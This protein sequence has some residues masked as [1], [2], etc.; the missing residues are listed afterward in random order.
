MESSEKRAELISARDL[1]AKVEAAIKAAM[2]RVGG[3]GEP[4]PV[5]VK[6]ELIGR[7][8]NAADGAQRFADEVTK[9]IGKFGIDAEPAVLIIDKK[10]IAGF[11]DRVAVPR[12][13]ML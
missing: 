4:E 9:E 1:P 7:I 8:L 3:V 10:V 12:S 13:R 5:I 6:W 2:D 11:F